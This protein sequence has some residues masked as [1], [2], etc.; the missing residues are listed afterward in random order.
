MDR[1]GD[2]VFELTE[3]EQ[4]DLAKD[5]IE[6]IVSNNKEVTTD[7]EFITDSELGV[8]TG[9]KYVWTT[10]NTDVIAND[11]KFTAPDEDT[12]VEVTVKVYLDGNTEGE[13]AATWTYTVVAKVPSQSTGGVI[14]S[15]AYGGGGNSGA[16]LKSDF[17]ELYNTSDEDIDLTGWVVFYASATGQFKAQGTES[18]DTAVALSGVIKAKSFYLI[19]AAT[20]AGGTVD[21]PTPDATTGIA[22]GANGF[23]IALCNTDDVPEG[24]DSANVVD[25]VGAGGNANLYEGTGAAPAPSNTKAVVR[26]NLTDTNDNAAD[27]VAADPNPRNSSYNPN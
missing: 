6:N 7:L 16:T 27:F 8:L 9:V 5:E 20:G 18:Y 12:D 4:L 26:T 23:K 3:E 11:G 25:F 17:I 1:D 24:P 22:M 19:K 14:I 10:N 15:Q 13:P 21:L 2:L